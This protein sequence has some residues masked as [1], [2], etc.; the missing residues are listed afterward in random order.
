MAEFMYDLDMF[1]DGTSAPQPIPVKK[2]KPKRKVRVLVD[3]P[4]VKK[5]KF[6]ISQRKDYLRTFAIIACSLVMTAIVASFISL[7]VYINCTDHE[8]AAIQEQLDIARSENVILNV[9]KDSMISYDE[10]RKVAE[11]KGMIQ[12]DRYQVTYFNLSNEDY[13]VVNP[14]G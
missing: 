5:E 8:I 11:E 9:K 3:T 13:G 14:E 2:E 4:Q 10:I 6:L 7:G 1:D 12:R